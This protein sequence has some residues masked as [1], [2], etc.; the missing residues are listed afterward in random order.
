MAKELTILL[1]IKNPELLKLLRG[2]IEETKN[3][4]VQESTSTSSD[5]LLLNSKTTPDIIKNYLRIYD[6]VRHEE[7]GKLELKQPQQND[8][9]YNLDNAI[10]VVYSRWCH[11]AGK[12]GKSY[13]RYKL[14]EFIEQEKVAIFY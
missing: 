8:N 1:A 14:M 3:V 5:K 6:Y 9:I 10:N 7:T 2:L 4:E 11:N 12:D 13:M